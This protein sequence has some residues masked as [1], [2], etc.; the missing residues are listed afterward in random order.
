MVTNLDP[1]EEYQLRHEDFV[2]DGDR[3]RAA[4][5]EHLASASRPS[6]STSTA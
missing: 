5:L 6:R 1:D 4:Q 3:Q 2:A